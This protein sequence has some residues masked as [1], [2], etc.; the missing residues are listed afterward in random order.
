MDYFC[1]VPLEDVEFRPARYSNA[2]D[3]GKGFYVQYV[4][5]SVP[6]PPSSACQAAT[7]A[8]VKT[9]EKSRTPVPQMCKEEGSRRLDVLFLPGYEGERL[10]APNPMPCVGVTR[11]VAPSRFGAPPLVHTRHALSNFPTEEKP[12]RRRR[13]SVGEG[14]LRG[15]LL[16]CLET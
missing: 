1:S 8:Q 6:P 12:G 3:A 10:V 7:V 9:G 15:G 16:P 4:S 14:E 5:P 11:L 13:I 2:L